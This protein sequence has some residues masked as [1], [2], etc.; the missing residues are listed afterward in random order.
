[1]SYQPFQP[2]QY[3]KKVL[4]FLSNKLRP[5]IFFYFLKVL[6]HFEYVNL[7]SR[8]FKCRNL[9]PIIRPGMHTWASIDLNIKG[10]KKVPSSLEC[11]KGQQ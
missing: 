11:T 6:F 9:V 4:S 1:M 8:L 7:S 3:Q 5:N 2:Q 10:G